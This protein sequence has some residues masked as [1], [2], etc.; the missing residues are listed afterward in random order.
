MAARSLTYF[1]SDVHLGL[2]VKDPADREVRFVRFLRGIP[3]DRTEA[4]YL[5]GDI[6]DFWY[7]YHDVV[8]KGSIRVFAALLDLMDAGVR[9]YFFQGNHDIWTYH[10]FADMGMTILQQPCVVDIHGKKFC[11]GHGDG[12]GPGH[13]WYKVMRWCFRNYVI[14]ALF[15][16]VHPYIAFRLGKGWSKQSRVAKNIDY[17]FRGTDEPLYKFAEDFSA[18]QPVDYFIFGHFHVAV[19]MELPGGARLLVLKDWM[20]PATADY[21]VFD[22]GRST[23]AAALA[24]ASSVEGT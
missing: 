2:D 3:K 23:L 14:Q 6:W 1:V 18:R 17:R 24:N 12:L 21:L 7:E 10:Y 15:N 19:D 22:S 11:L 20:D 9:V 16:L 8:P 13:F 4:L 5:L